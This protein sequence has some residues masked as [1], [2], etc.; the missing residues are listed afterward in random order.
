MSDDA[1]LSEVS[2]ADPRLWKD[3]PPHEL[4]EEMRRSCPVHWSA[5]I[6]G[7]PNEEGFWSIT[8]TADI[9]QVTLDWR[10]FSSERGG[11]E[12]T[13]HVSPI[14]FARAEFI[15]MD[16]PKHDRLKAL[17]L[18]G[19]TAERVAEDEGWIR[20]IVTTVLDRL[21][22][23]ETC[24]LV[25][26]VSQPVVSRVIHRMLGIPEEDD[27]RWAEYMKLYMA[28]EDPEI[29]PGGVD[30]YVNEILPLVVD[31][32]TKLVRQ[33]IEKPGD[34]LI[35]VIAQ[36]EIDGQRL[37]DI[38][39]AMGVLLLVSAGNDS[40]MATYVSAM[41][42]L[43]ELPDQRQQVLEDMSLVPGVV[44]EALRMYPAFFAFRRTATHDVELGG[45]KIKENDK[46][47]MW[48]VS[49]NRDAA[50]H[51]NPHVFD[52]RRNPQH[53]A[54]GAGG[55][56]FCLGSSL[57]RLELRVMIEETL[58]RFPEMT[59]IGDAPHAESFLVNQFKSLPVR[60]R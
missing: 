10:T 59:V 15:G 37:S 36:A 35:S 50:E 51:E 22:G 58:M 57:A 2:V 8:S 19:F 46:V 33:R 23:R 42:A 16:P 3:G 21:E 48:Y 56:H 60:L 53:Q 1:S 40:T 18:K 44:E 17:F 41:K 54:F 47:V 49:S 13:N 11:V 39:M 30:A 34:D 43:M 25:S 38:E 52:V 45:R 5:E 12:I 7:L 20:E 6:P 14:E 4:F 9:R 28:K 24:D 27:A 32:A 26:D 31:E 29:N 55:R